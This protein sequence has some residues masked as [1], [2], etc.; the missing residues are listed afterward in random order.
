MYYKNGARSKKNEAKQ[1]GNEGDSRARCGR[2]WAR[3]WEQRR[4]G[5]EICDAPEGSLATRECPRGARTQLPEP[6][7]QLR[8]TG[9]GPEAQT[10]SVEDGKPAVGGE[11]VTRA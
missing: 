9:Q 1:R 4:Q 3:V 8:G 6:L 7:G 5:A 10:P 2:R 11:K